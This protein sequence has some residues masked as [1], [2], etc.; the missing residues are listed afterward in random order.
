LDGASDGEALGL[1]E[2]ES[3]GEADGDAVGLELGEELSVGLL[4]GALLGKKLP[5][6]ALLGSPHSTLIVSQGISMMYAQ[7]VPLMS[8]K[9]STTQ[10][11]H[12]SGSKSLSMYTTIVALVIP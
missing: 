4:D 7:K 3:L 10:A 9:S 2:G 1:P 11:V 12:S 5:L 8:I 6:G